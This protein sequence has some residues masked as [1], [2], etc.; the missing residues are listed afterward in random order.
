MKKR[1]WIRVMGLEI[2]KC[3]NLIW[4]GEW[5]LKINVCAFPFSCF[6]IKPN[7][8][9]L[10][11]WTV[12][13]CASFHGSQFLLTHSSYH[14]QPHSTQLSILYR[15]SCKKFL[16]AHVPMFVYIYLCACIFKYMYISYLHI[17]II[18]PTTLLSLRRA[19]HVSLCEIEYH[20]HM[21]LK[22]TL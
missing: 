11:G 9:F 1:T 7:I 13:N 5:R 17:S 16:C 14:L 12:L 10:L 6:P 19:S 21:K 15:V 3:I 2:E 20:H 18:S 4:F 22:F 8:Y